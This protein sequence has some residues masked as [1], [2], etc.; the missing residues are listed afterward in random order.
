M[1]ASIQLIQLTD[2]VPSEVLVT[3]IVVHLWTTRN[4]IQFA[5]ICPITQ[6]H[7]SHHDLGS[8][9]DADHLIWP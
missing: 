7:D 4:G 3:W 8:I 5:A 9:A 6:Q 1:T 2:Y